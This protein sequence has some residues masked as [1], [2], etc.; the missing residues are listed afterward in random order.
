MATTTPFDTGP[1]FEAIYDQDTQGTNTQEL[2][3][4]TQPGNDTAGDTSATTPP[5][6]Q[7]P[8]D[9]AGKADKTGKA[10]NDA[11]PPAQAGEGTGGEDQKAE[12]DDPLDKLIGTPKRLRQ[13]LKDTKKQADELRKQLEHNQR[14]SE[15][16]ARAEY[17]RVKADYEKTVSSLKE[18]LESTR[19]KLAEVDYTR[20]DEFVNSYYK[21][22]EKAVARATA[23]KNGDGKNLSKMEIIQLAQLYAENP[24]EA[25]SRIEDV[26]GAKSV[27][28][29]KA[30]GDVA[31]ALR[32]YE[33][34]LAKAEEISRA[35][36]R[37]SSKHSVE[38][39]LRQ[40]ELYNKLA[41]THASSRLRA[42]GFNEQEQ[43]RFDE[44]ASGIDEALS[45]A[46]TV[47]SQLITLAKIR[48]NVALGAV[49]MERFNAAQQRI[50]ELE[51]KLSEYEST[52]PDVAPTHGG[53][54]S[55][56]DDVFSLVP[57]F[58]P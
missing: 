12:A 38:D 44:V 49:I 10:G 27:S 46:D 2:Q 1:S 37:E 33:E 5:H 7:P 14:E 58:R 25:E 28:A 17:E 11:P 36:R 21:P 47:E 19:R 43:K 29:I 4:N 48:N 31:D 26:V 8:A 51:E 39:M 34:G 9:K 35:T 22:Y 3:E 15:A 20:S 50:A 55:G 57:G 41:G 52:S 6:S 23:I 54:P 53:Q 45:S 42:F 30:I 56:D 18:Q 24:V 40:R 16:K 13:A 32:N